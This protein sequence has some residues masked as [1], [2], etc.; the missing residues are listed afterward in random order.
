MTNIVTADKLKTQG[1]SCLDEALNSTGQAVITVQGRERYV[2]VSLEHYN[3]LRDCEL[4]AALAE[5]RRDI[6]TGKT[7]SESV[8]QHIARITVG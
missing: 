4:E 2:V 7:V 8:E 3:Y 5:T 1:I 6:Q